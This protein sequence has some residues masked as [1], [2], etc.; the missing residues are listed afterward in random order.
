M[1]L[2]THI[3]GKSASRRFSRSS[4][5]L[6][7]PK[8]HPF[9]AEQVADLKP[10]VGTFACKRFEKSILP[11]LGG[12][13]Q[14]LHFPCGGGGKRGGDNTAYDPHKGCRRIKVLGLLTHIAGKNVSL[15]FSLSNAE[16]LAMVGLCFYVAR[17]LLGFMNWGCATM[18]H[19]LQFCLSSIS[20]NAA[21]TFGRSF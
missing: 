4:S 3:A 8:R 10:E 7:A 17:R 21:T 6:L 16:L 9:W 1:G 20:R 5:E 14:N 15:R 19:I 18:F 11:R 12:G 2:L 13:T